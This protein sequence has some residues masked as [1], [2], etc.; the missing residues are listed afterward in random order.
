MFWRLCSNPIGVESAEC[1]LQAETVLNIIKEQ[2][3]KHKGCTFIT[4]DL[5]KHNLISQV[6]IGKALN[7]L[8]SS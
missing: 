1:R 4:G 8:I 6:L 2:P 3:L 5:G 7:H